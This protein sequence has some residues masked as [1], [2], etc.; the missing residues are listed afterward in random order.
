M[1]LNWSGVPPPMVHPSPYLATR[2]ILAGPDPLQL[3]ELGLE[4]PPALVEWG[5]GS[6]I[7]VLAQSDGD[8]ERETA[9][10]QRIDRRGLLRQHRPV[11]AEWAEEDVGGQANSIRDG[12]GRR[13]SDERLIVAVHDSVDRSERR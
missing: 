3:L 13:Q 6:R 12:R 9:I 7:V 8:S 2:P 1:S 10:R 5:S 11:S 4:Q